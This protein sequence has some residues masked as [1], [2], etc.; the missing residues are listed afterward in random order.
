[1]AALLPFASTLDSGYYSVNITGT[2]WPSIYR[3]NRMHVY[4]VSVI[5]LLGKLPG[6]QPIS[7]LLKPGVNKLEDEP[8]SDLLTPSVK[9]CYQLI[10]GRW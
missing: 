5:S 10:I 1:M 3:Y 8:N 9:E 7:N 6:C 4:K 2:Y